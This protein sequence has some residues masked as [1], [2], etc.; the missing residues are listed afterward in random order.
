[1]HKDR[2]NEYLTK[3]MGMCWHD[4]QC[5]GTGDED[6]CIHCNRPESYV[7]QGDF[8]TWNGFGVLFTWVMDQTWAQGFRSANG[9]DYTS[10]EIQVGLIDPV[11]FANTVCGY[12]KS[13]EFLI[14]AQE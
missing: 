8:Y 4:F 3:A 2:V 10:H 13:H 6:R 5:I 1:M 11:V 12:L 7:H 14:G 9:S